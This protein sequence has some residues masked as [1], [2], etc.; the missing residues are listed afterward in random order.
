VPDQKPATPHEPP[1]AIPTRAAAGIKKTTSEKAVD[2]GY[3][4]AAHVRDVV[5]DRLSRLKTG[6]N[7][8]NLPREYLVLLEVLKAGSSLSEKEI[9]KH[10]D[11]IMGALRNPKLY[12]DVV[13]DAYEIARANGLTLEEGLMRLA[14]DE[15]LTIKAVPR[16]EGILQGDT[17]FDD[18]VTQPVSI[19]DLPFKGAPNAPMS[20]GYHGSVMHIVQDLVVNRANLGRTSYA[21]RK[22]LG[23]ADRRITITNLGGELEL[24]RVGDYVWRNT[25]DLYVRGH[26]PMPEMGG[27]VLKQ[28]L[29]LR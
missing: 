5:T 10:I 26:L 8:A 28:F 13:A 11:G 7:R 18:F 6:M 9:L 25:Y 29:K 1:T 17:F 3:R 4:D 20:G 2:L 27:A 19:H 14:R 22:T 12:G 24:V 21:F 23:A 16:Q 15:G